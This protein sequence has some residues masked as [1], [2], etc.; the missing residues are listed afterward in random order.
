MPGH[1]FNK[2][3]DGDV[4]YVEQHDDGI[5]LVSYNRDWVYVVDNDDKPDVEFNDDGSVHINTPG[6]YYFNHDI[7][8]W[9]LTVFRINDDGTRTVFTDD[10]DDP[11][12][13]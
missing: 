9:R 7:R 10:R 2:L 4:I 5:H 12:L 11:A 6:N 1:N 13:D 3:R 8:D